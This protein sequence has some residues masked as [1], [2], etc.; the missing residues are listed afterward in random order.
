MKKHI[1]FKLATRSRREKATKSILNI[2]DMC[3]SDDYT[4]LMSCDFDDETMKDFHFDDDRVIVVYGENK[5]K[6]EAINRDIEKVE[7]WDILINTSD[8]MVFVK[9]GFDNIIRKDFGDNLDQFIHYS[10]GN[11]KANISTMSIFGREY[12]DRFN[13]IYHPD[14]KS[15]WSDVEA[16]DVAVIMDKYKYMGDN[17]ILFR[18]MHPAWGLAETDEQY[19]RTEARELWDYDFK[20]ITDRKNNNYH[21]PKE[22]IKKQTK[23]AKL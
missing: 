3:E 11:Q 8:D 9:K 22:L 12:Y 15:L 19:K 7:N 2:I 5:T 6:I 1:L 23:Y 20:V 17:N 16:T 14:Y 10:D 18:H 4:I 21:L 13:Y